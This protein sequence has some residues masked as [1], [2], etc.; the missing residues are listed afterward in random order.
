MVLAPPGDAAPT[1]TR[2]P[3]S[4]YPVTTAARRRGAKCLLVYAG[5]LLARGAWRVRNPRF[6]EL[7]ARLGRLTTGHRHMSRA[8]G[9]PLVWARRASVPVWARGVVVGGEGVWG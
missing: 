8:S 3:L 4:R 1:H 6:G 5:G 9:L 2:T 7:G